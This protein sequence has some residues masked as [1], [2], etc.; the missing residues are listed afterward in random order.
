ML[1]EFISTKNAAGILAFNFWNTLCESKKIDDPFTLYEFL[2]LRGEGDE[3]RGMDVS[4][5]AQPGETHHIISSLIS[6][7]GEGENENPIA[8]LGVKN[9][10]E[11][12]RIIKLNNLNKMGAI[13][14]DREVV[15]LCRSKDGENVYTLIT[16]PHPLKAFNPLKLEQ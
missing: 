13:D 6:C 11:A 2:A 8:V 14:L 1:P 10:K 7:I 3:I 12:A 9:S 5:R 4:R 16:Y 15:I